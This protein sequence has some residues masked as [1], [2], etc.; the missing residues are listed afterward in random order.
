MA[1]RPATSAPRVFKTKWFTKAARSAL[2]PDDELCVAVAELAK[3]QGNDLGGGVWKKRLSGNRHRSIVLT[4]HS[5]FWVYEFLFAKADS[6]SIS[7][8]G[9]SALR[10]IAGDYADADGSVSGTTYEEQRLEGDLQCRKRR[11]I[12]VR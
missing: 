1:K 7:T 10:K 6:E 11:S 4:K 9:L 5:K 3:G 12:A 2:I 8:A